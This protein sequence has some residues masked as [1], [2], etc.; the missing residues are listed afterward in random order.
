MASAERIHPEADA[1]R[2]VPLGLQTSRG[3]PEFQMVS[4]SRCVQFAYFV[5]ILVLDKMAKS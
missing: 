5:K 3:E 2:A 4:H 1:A